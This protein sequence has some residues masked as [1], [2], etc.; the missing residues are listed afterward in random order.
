MKI[1]DK[2]QQFIEA[3]CVTGPGERDSKAN[4]YRA[5]QMWGVAGG[6]R[7]LLT[8][9]ELNDALRKKGFPE[10]RVGAAHDRGLLG[11]RAVLPFERG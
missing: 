3:S 4:I 1:E 9:R 8:M 6:E 11:L 5:Y 7:F 10:C 2:V